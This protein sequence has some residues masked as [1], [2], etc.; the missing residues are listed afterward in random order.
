M[1]AS[2]HQVMLLFRSSDNPRS[3]RRQTKP[4]R[5]PGEVCVTWSG[6]AKGCWERLRSAMAE[7]MR[8]RHGSLPTERDLGY[9][10]RGH[11]GR[12]VNGQ[13]FKALPKSNAG[14]PWTVE[15]ISPC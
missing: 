1:R 14:I 12:V 10:L 8:I 2:A 7:L 11:K 5:L 6:S 13:R 15:T 9:L 4:R 3:A